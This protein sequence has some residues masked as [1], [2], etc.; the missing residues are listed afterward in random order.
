MVELLLLTIDE[1]RSED[2]AVPVLRAKVPDDRTLRCT[3]ER[4]SS[5]LE[6]TPEPVIR[7][8]SAILEGAL[9][10]SELGHWETDHAASCGWLHEG[11]CPR[12]HG[13]LQ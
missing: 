3:S 10:V 11:P 2:S 12:C 7:R 6:D 9:S 5:L 1:T 8:A 13:A 4:L